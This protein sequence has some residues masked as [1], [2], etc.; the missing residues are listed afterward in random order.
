MK[1]INNILKRALKDGFDLS[2]L[3]NYSQ[4]SFFDG[5]YDYFVEKKYFI[6]E[7]EG[8]LYVGYNI[9]EDVAEISVFGS[10]MK[11]TP[12]QEQGFFDIFVELFRYIRILSDSRDN[13]IKQEDAST[14]DYSEEE[15]S[16]EW[17]L[18][19]FFI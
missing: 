1:Q 10:T 9:I 12:L 8:V 13:K 16:E 4:K 5:L 11:I 14:E 2:T 6:T 7:E 3:P 17:W 19:K 15:S 18:W